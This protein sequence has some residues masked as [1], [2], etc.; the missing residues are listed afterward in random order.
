MNKK[1]ARFAIDG[2]L[3]ILFLSLLMLPISSIGLSGFKG[4]S[5]E[6]LGSRTNDRYNTSPELQYNEDIR[7]I[8]PT[9]QSTQSTEED[10][11]LP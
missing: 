7:T 11:L 5:I 6:V 2:L 9:K 3:V 1:F 4:Q 8:E 10:I